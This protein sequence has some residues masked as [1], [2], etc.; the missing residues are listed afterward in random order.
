MRR[1]HSY[2]PVDCE[3]HFCIQRK[4]LI[5]RCIAQLVGNPKKGGH[6]F[7]IWAPRQTGKTW[8]MRQIKEEIPRSYPD[9]FAVYTCS[10]G[11]LRGMSYSASTKFKESEALPKALIRVLEQEFPQKPIVKTWRE[12]RH[13]FS[14]EHALWD[15]PLILLIDEVDTAPPVLLDVI[16]GRF[17]E[18]YLNREPHW[19]HGLALI[20]VRA[21]L[22]IESQRGSPFNVQRSLHVPNLTE[23]EVKELYHQY[24]EE[25]GQTIVPEVVEAVYKTTNGQPG[26][27][28]WFGELL[29]ETYNSSP[30]QPINPDTWK[31][32]WLNARTVEVNNTLTNLIAKARDPE[33]QTFL[34]KVFATSD[35]PFSFHTP[36][37]NYLYLHG[38]LEPMTITEPNGELNNVCRF[39]SPF[40][41]QCLYNAL[42]GE[43]F[44]AGMIILALEPLDELTDVFEGN[45]LNIPALLQRYRDYLARLKA[46]GMNPWKDQPRRKTDVHLMEA[47]GHFHLYAWLKDVLQDLCVVSPEFPTGNGKVDIHLKCGQK[48]GIIEVKSFRNA[49]RL[50]KDRTKAAQYAKSLKLDV[51]T[52]A[53]FVPVDDDTVLKKLSG[54]YAIQ[55]VQVIVVAIGWV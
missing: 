14:T 43:F 23:D 41:Q 49:S 46:K 12:F 24:Q 2:G 32:V 10:F 48:Q 3:D 13:V 34:T 47:V 39:T 7:T 50:K 51:V 6:Y 55:G 25:S 54:E 35:I 19:L 1:F 37:H 27:V 15:R 36:L 9:Q 52:M 18:M 8:L 40:I 42:S 17:R 38:I 53:V 29:T 21:V 5:E 30:D 33:Y 22:G 20:G 16:A 26:L 11:D 4:E 31:L 44:E 45:A 28:S